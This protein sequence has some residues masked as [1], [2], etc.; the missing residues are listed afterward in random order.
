MTLYP[1]DKGRDMRAVVQRVSEAAV[2]IGNDELGRIGKGVLVLLGVGPDDHME[3]INY[4]TDKVVHLRIFADPEDKMN[5][6]VLDIGGSI[7]VVSQFTLWGDCRK[8]R[9]PS[10]TAAA[11]PDMAKTLYEAFVK[12]L[13][14]YPVKV[15]SGRFQEMMSVHLI[16]DGPVTLL[17]DSRKTF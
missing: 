17:L 7:L 4:L 6:S 1:Q 13:R 14:H 12:R 5:Y 8:G 11:P 2:R 10:F 9:R 16:N 3:D 15:E